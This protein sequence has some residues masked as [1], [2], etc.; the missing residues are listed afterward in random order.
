MFKDTYLVNKNKK[1]IISMEDASRRLLKSQQGSIFFEMESCSVAQAGVQWC[2]LS[3]P[4]P[5]LPRFKQFSY[6]SLLSSWDY[7][8]VS[9]CLANFFVFLVEL[10]FLY[11]GQAGLKPPTS[12]DPPA[13]AFQSAGITGIHHCAQL[14]FVFFVEKS[15]TMLV[16]LSS[17]S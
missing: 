4:Q 7:R 12:G 11:I 9:P 8:R 15:F 17:N 5:L 10:R 16:T 3:S 2:D 13:S 14:I 1:G 6:L